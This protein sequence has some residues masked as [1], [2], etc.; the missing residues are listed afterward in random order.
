M[1]DNVLISSFLAGSVQTLIGHPFDTIKT[2]IQIF[3]G[4]YRES[5]SRIY[6]K[7]GVRSFYKGYLPPLIAGC[8][9]NSF[10]FTTENI[11]QNYYSNSFLTGF[12]S[13]GFTAFLL[14]PAELIKCHIQS[15]KNKVLSIK[16]VFKKLKDKKINLFTG[17]TSTIIRDSIGLGIY[18]GT[19]NN[20]QTYYNNP[21]LNGGISGI[22]SWIASYPIDLVKTKKQM[23]NSPYKQIFSKIKPKE[24]VRGMNI[25]L[26]RSFLV[27][28]S[29]FYTYENLIQVI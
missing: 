19:Y 10:L 22:F 6:K 24:Y 21:F 28:A 15:E 2:R 7:E 14:S 23:Y 16:Q 8:F 18:F 26:I 25:V 9:Q 1:N 17:L 11:F 20:L 3:K 13:G 29:I 12:L 27:N 4:S 5:I